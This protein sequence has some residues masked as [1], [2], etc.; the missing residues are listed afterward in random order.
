MWSEDKMI[1]V[2]KKD[3]DGRSYLEKYIFRKVFDIFG[4][5]YLL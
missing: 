2:N 4:D 5:F 3:A 1:D